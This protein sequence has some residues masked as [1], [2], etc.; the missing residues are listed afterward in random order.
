M[1]RS[2]QISAANRINREVCLRINVAVIERNVCVMAGRRPSRGEPVVIEKI[3][4]Y[5]GVSTQPPSRIRAR[6][7]MFEWK[8]GRLK[9]IAATLAA[10]PRRAA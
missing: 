2:S 3:L 6:S 9:Y 4:V 7:A 1:P 10:P 8:S 5:I